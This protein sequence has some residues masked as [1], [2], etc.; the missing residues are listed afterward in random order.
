MIW[1]SLFIALSI[2]FMLFCDRGW[3]GEMLKLMKNDHSYVL[4]T[5]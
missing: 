2:V 4:S 5:I 1:V 3:D